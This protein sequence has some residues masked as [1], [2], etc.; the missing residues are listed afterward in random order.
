MSVS[1][2][3]ARGMVSSLYPTTG[4]KAK[5]NRMPA[6]QILA[7]YH[8]AKETGKF[9]KKSIEDRKKLQEP[10]GNHQMTIFEYLEGKTI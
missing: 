3:Y 7:I 1:L 2:E 4:W 5:V 9:S 10:D 6:N 8:H